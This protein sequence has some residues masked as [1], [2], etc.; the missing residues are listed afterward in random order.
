MRGRIISSFYLPLAQNCKPMILS[1]REM[2]FTM[3][4]EGE[5]VAPD[6]MQTILFCLL[7]LLIMKASLKGA[8]TIIDGDRSVEIQKMMI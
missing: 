4:H 5:L 3:I 6:L 1:A 8:S 2:A 7:D